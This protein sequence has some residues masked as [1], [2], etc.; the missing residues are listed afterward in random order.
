MAS[1][2]V[3][4]MKWAM[5]SSHKA[6]HLMLTS[7]VKHINGEDMIVDINNYKFKDMNGLTPL[8]EYL[9][10]PK[11]CLECWFDYLEKYALVSKKLIISG[12]FLTLNSKHPKYKTHVV[13]RRDDE[14]FKKFEP[15]PVVVQYH[16]HSL[17]CAVRR[18]TD[19]K[20]ENFAMCCLIMFKPFRDIKDIKGKYKTYYEQLFDQEGN[21]HR[22]VLS[23]SGYMVIENN[24]DRWTCKFAS[25]IS[26]KNH[27]EHIQVATQNLHVRYPEGN[28]V[29]S[30]EGVFEEIVHGDL[31][32]YP[33]NYF[34][35][36]SANID[37]AIMEMGLTENSQQIAYA[38]QKNIIYKRDLDEKSIC[39]G[40]R[41]KKEVYTSRCGYLEALHYS[42]S[43]EV[44]SLVDAAI[45]SLI[46]GVDVKYYEYIR[47]RYSIPESEHVIHYVSEKKGYVTLKICSSLLEIVNIY[48]FTKDQKRA[49]I[50]GSIPLLKNIGDVDHDSNHVQVF[51]VIQGLAGSG[52]SYVINAWK[53]LA[54]SWGQEYAVQCTSYTGIAAS[55]IHGRTLDSLIR[56]RNEK[57]AACIKLLVIDEV[58]KIF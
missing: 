14:T 40:F 49:F 12:D 54:L 41:S 45:R 25:E 46:P 35:Y 51:G 6:V 39:E 36:M 32:T 47:R 16:G 26:A 27:Y 31:S 15:T 21:I 52:K 11:E 9:L 20:K 38:S 22:S 50:I 53:A 4:N 33:Q 28:G 2:Y 18:D 43:V 23:Q 17:K 29:E 58:N 24:E 3:M 19:E 55:N 56:S 7:S 44:H 1:W 30:C 57:L 48:G 8:A 10:R 13:I 42:K 5:I 37:E 34:D